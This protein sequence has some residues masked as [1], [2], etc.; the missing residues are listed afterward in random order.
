MLRF[1]S[2]FCNIIIILLFCMEA[3]G[4]GV[5]VARDTTSAYGDFYDVTNGTVDADGNLDLTVR[6]LDV[7][8]TVTG[9]EEGATP[10]PFPTPG[11][12]PFTDY[13]WR[14]DG[15]W[16]KTPTASPTATPTATPTESPTP[17]PVATATPIPTP[18]GTPASDFFFVGDYSWRKLV[19]A[20]I[21][22]L[23]Y[24]PAIAT[25]AGTP[26]AVFWRGDK[27]WAAVTANGFPTPAETPATAFFWRGDNTW[28]IPAGD[29][30]AVPEAE[31]TPVYSGAKFP[32]RNSPGT[33]QYVYGGSTTGAKMNPDVF[34]V[35]GHGVSDMGWVVIVTSGPMVGRKLHVLGRWEDDGGG[36]PYIELSEALVDGW[37]GANWT[38]DIYNQ[39]VLAS[40]DYFWAG[41]RSWRVPDFEPA[42]ATPAGT[43]EASIWSGAKT[44]IT[45]ATAASYAGDAHH[46]DGYRAWQ[47]G[48]LSTTHTA[49]SYANNSHNLDGNRLG[50]IGLLSTTHTAATYANNAHNIDG[51]R[52]P[53]I[54]LLST[55]HTAATYAN[56]AH[57]LDSYRAWQFAQWNHDHAATYVPYTQA[58]TGTSFY[59]NLT[60]WYCGAT[61]TGTVQITLP[62]ASTM[63]YLKICGYT[64]NANSTLLNYF[65]IIVGC[66]YRTS[67]DS[68]LRFTV[69]MTGS[70][71]GG[72]I[73]YGKITATGVPVIL[74]GEVGTAWS[75]TTLAVTEDLSTYILG[76]PA[77][78]ATSKIT[79]E[80]GLTINTTPVVSTPLNANATQTANKIYA[81][82]VSGSETAPTWRVAV[83][84]DIPA[85]IARD[86]EVAAAYLPLTGGTISG[87]VTVNAPVTGTGLTVAAVAGA[88]LVTNGAMA[89]P[90]AAPWVAA[91]LSGPPTLSLTGGN[92]SFTGGSLYS[93]TCTESYSATP[94]AGLA[95]TTAGHMY[96][97]TYKVTISAGN[98]IV[99]W[100]LGGST[101]VQR[102]LNVGGPNT[103][104]DYLYPTSSNQ[105]L[106]CEVVGGSGETATGTV[107]DVTLSDCS[108]LVT[109]QE[110][111]VTGRVTADEYVTTSPGSK[112]S[113]EESLEA[114]LKVRTVGGRID[115]KSW[116]QE[117]QTSETLEWSVEGGGAAFRASAASAGLTAIVWNTTES[118][119]T[120]A[121]GGV[122]RDDGSTKTKTVTTGLV[123]RDAGSLNQ[124]LNIT[125]Q[126]LRGER[127]QRKELEKRVEAM[128]S[129]LGITN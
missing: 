36:W 50:A 23:D 69:S 127:K 22:A 12:T 15:A 89:T 73:R 53:S 28:G 72:V 90:S 71:P 56:T 57:L 97:V 2:S 80:S 34:A 98:V 120:K 101:N 59:R 63:R 40:E 39:D 126:A 110:V 3:Q 25:P 47:I 31:A 19:A 35:G 82:P 86:A 11:E 30:A 79:D 41:D 108:G 88:D 91:V 17:T 45:T 68:W 32:N 115:H 75:Y 6:N 128:E 14:G 124:M 60:S 49:A 83:D 116:P 24:E 109:V 55:T 4:Q 38:F 21:P 114:L 103:Y 43:P 81:G 70:F 122:Y 99:K 87:A 67:T 77:E 123:G 107:D 26:S 62:R 85:A 76:D 106:V 105:N 64:Y 112:L 118:V 113:D 33:N 84:A 95:A 96:K 8:G 111:K 100:T 66:Y 117:A 7:Y 18:S 37:Y 9:I 94:G 46:L 10:T 5:L 16:A 52:L 102:I 20:D 93:A 54:G 78:W 27:T 48:L 74:L 42:I 104:T 129:K 13:W 58:W 65:E 1:L 121:G 92:F 29:V 44:W 61:A 119:V 51:N 125:Y